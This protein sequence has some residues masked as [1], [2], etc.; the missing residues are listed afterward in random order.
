MLLG[1]GLVVGAVILMIIVIA[2]FVKSDED[3]TAG[4]VVWM[5]LELVCLLGICYGCSVIVS[6][7]HDSLKQSRIDQ[8]EARSERESKPRQATVAVTANLGHTSEH[9][10]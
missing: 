3:D 2:M 10:V 7:R 6:A 1:I 5:V 8:Q 4:R 9:I